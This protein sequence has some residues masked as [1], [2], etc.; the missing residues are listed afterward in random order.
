MALLATSGLSDLFAVSFDGLFV[1]VLVVLALLLE[2]F[3]AS[4]AVVG[5]STEHGFALPSLVLVF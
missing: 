1:V 2:L 5:A 3:H 4:G